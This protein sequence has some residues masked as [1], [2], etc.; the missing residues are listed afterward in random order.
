[1]EENK[2]ISRL[3]RI[4]RKVYGEKAVDFSLLAFGGLVIGQFVTVNEADISIIVFGVVISVLGV[5][6]SYYLMRPLLDKEER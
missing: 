5:M 6:A 1:M 2:K 3:N 4:H